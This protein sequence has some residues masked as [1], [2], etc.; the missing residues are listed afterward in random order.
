MRSN[1]IQPS[2]QFASELFDH[3]FALEGS[4]LR[5]EGTRAWE[6]AN[7][8]IISRKLRSL[9]GAGSKASSNDDVTSASSCWVS[10]H[11][12]AVGSTVTLTSKGGSVSLLLSKSRG[13]TRRTHR[14]RYSKIRIPL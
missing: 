4:D 14:L 12:L 6:S 7:K 10:L 2:L 9:V 11:P 1:G 13:G 3:A 5:S 8:V